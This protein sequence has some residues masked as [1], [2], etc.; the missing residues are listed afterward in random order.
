MIPQ[1][2]DATPEKNQQDENRLESHLS[3]TKRLQILKVNVSSQELMLLWSHWFLSSSQ[4]NLAALA[5]PHFTFLAN[6]TI[7]DPNP[8]KKNVLPILCVENK[9]LKFLGEL[10]VNDLSLVS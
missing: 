5:T 8:W 2:T 1:E 3:M 7:F 9:L 4:D 10:L 6:H